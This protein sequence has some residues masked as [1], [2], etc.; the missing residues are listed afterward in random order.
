LNS[1]APVRY[2]VPS[3]E[4]FN[5]TVSAAL[6][7]RMNVRDGPGPGLFGL[8][9]TRALPPFLPLRFGILE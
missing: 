4:L 3:E 9:W 8:S 2:A 6:N 5:W 1:I 7:V